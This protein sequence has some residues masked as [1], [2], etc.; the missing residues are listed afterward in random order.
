[1]KIGLIGAGLMGNVHL[2]AYAKIENVEVVG[3]IDVR[4][5][6]AKAGAELVGARPFSS[7]KELV[8]EVDDHESRST[9][10]H[11]T[12]GDMNQAMLEDFANGVRHGSPGGAN[13]VDGLRALEVAV[14]AYQSAHA[15]GPKRVER[16]VV[17]AA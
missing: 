16:A 8:E 15:A 17:H 5:E 1:L 14:A 4:R 7:Y 12:G 11:N 2:K 13:A 6:A 10:W 9:E 3:V